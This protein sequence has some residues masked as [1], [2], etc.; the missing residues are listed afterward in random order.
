MPSV[1][2]F[3]HSTSSSS[4]RPSFLRNSMTALTNAYHSLSLLTKSKSDEIKAQTRGSQ[5]PTTPYKRRLRE[6]RVTAT[7]TLLNACQLHAAVL[8]RVHIRISSRGHLPSVQ[9]QYVGAPTN[10][11]FPDL[12]RDRSIQ[13]RQIQSSFAREKGR[14]RLKRARPDLLSRWI[15]RCSGWRRNG[16]C[17]RGPPQ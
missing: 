16:K 15:R 17:E 7:Q 14:T 5:T 12:V 9:Y 4:R 1:I 6:C 10:T 3:A 11:G 13:E 8:R 2:V